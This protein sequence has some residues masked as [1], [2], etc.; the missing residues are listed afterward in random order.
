[1]LGGPGLTSLGCLRLEDLH[2]FPCAEKRPYEV[3]VDDALERLERY[4]FYW[5]LGRVNARV[6]YGAENQ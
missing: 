1:M 5:D 2:G 3:D 6:L 4:F